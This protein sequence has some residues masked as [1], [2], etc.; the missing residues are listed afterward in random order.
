MGGSWVGWGIKSRERGGGKRTM[1]EIE[2]FG[3]FHLRLVANTIDSGS[4]NLPDAPLLRRTIS[5]KQMVQSTLRQGV[6]DPKMDD[7]ARIYLCQLGAY[8]RRWSCTNSTVPVSSY[9]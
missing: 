1:T 3:P 5:K 4:P 2:K 8:S 9:S 6:M 7:A